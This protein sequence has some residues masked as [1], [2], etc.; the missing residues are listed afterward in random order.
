[1]KWSEWARFRQEHD[2]EVIAVIQE[3]HAG[4]TIVVRG[5]LGMDA[6]TMK[7]EPVDSRLGKILHMLFADATRSPGKPQRVDLFGGLHLAMIIEIDNFFRMQLHREGVYPSDTEWKTTLA[8]MPVHL[9]A[10]TPEMFEH[11][12]KFYMRG[13]WPLDVLANAGN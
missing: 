3:A 5:D 4:T 8:H 1:M 6:S 10:Q 13:S 11:A 2:L 7:M 12:G 9:P